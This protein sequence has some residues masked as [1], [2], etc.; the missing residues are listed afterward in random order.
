[1]FC[2]GGGF[3]VTKQLSLL[4]AGFALWEQLEVGFVLKG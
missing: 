2:Q 3:A 1:M 4:S